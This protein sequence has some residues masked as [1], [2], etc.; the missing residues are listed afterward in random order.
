MPRSIGS[1]LTAST[2]RRLPE[3]GILGPSTQISSLFGSPDTDRGADFQRLRLGLRRCRSDPW[4]DDAEAFP[5]R[6]PTVPE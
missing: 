1:F 2:R 6:T 4:S 3:L 5:G